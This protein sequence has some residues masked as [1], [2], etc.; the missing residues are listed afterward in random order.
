MENS[1]SAGQSAA[2]FSLNNYFR[3]QSSICSVEYKFHNGTGTI[4][5]LEFP[6][7]TWRTLFMTSF[8]VAPINDPNEI[9]SLKVISEDKTIGNLNWTPDWV[10][11]LWKSPTEELN[12]T[13]IELIRKAKT[14]FSRKNN[15]SRQRKEFNFF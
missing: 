9:T 8:Q 13:V 5:G 7:N 6:V 4:I 14:I 1:T 12:V 15:C 3:H 11:T 10:E 2:P